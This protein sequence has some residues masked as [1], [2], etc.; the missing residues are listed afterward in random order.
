ME[1]TAFTLTLSPSSF[2]KNMK[3]NFYFRGKFFFCFLQH[4]RITWELSIKVL[5]LVLSTP[6]CSCIQM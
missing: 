3:Q 1:Y 2:V 6:S 4:V 5:I